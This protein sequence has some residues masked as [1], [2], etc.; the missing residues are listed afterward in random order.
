MTTDN[1]CWYLQN[2]QIQTNKTG[3]QRYSDI[4]P[5]SIP[6][7][8][9]GNPY[10]TGRLS[11]IDLLVLTSLGELILTLKLHIYIFTKPTYLNE[12][13]KCTEP[14]RSVKSSQ[15]LPLCYRGPSFN[16]LLKDGI[17]SPL[18]HLSHLSLSFFLAVFICLSFFPFSFQ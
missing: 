3:G 15:V 2:R 10:W 1:C 13:V 17:A 8:Y 4:S 18:S 5:F 7:F 6:W 12:E 11:T 9:P 16:Y 14:F